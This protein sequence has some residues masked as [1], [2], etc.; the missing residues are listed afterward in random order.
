MKYIFIILLVFIPLLIIVLFFSLKN[1]PII[2]EKEVL[3]EAIEKA[4]ERKNQEPV[5]TK[6]K[7]VEVKEDHK[8]LALE[9]IREKIA[10][11]NPYRKQEAIEKLIAIGDGISV[12]QIEEL[13]KDRTPSVVNRALDALGELKSETSIPLIDEVFKT[14]E[15]RQ[16]GYGESIRINAINA[17]GEIGSEQSIDMLGAELPKRNLILGSHVVTAMEKIKSEK[18]LPFLEEYQAFL[19]E[20]LANMPGAEEVGEYRYVWEQASKQVKEAID[21]IK[22]NSNK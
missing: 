9:E 3:K 22:D 10:S 21:T 6:E 8:Q 20:Q 2:E 16:D 17:L 1:K 14:N 5:K 12:R 18:S 11:G 15:I 4:E 19:N 7:V 13:A